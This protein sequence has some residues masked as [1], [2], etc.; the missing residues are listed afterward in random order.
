MFAKHLF[1]C[2]CFVFRIFFSL[3]LSSW[4]CL[5]FRYFWNMMPNYL[6]RNG[7]GWQRNQNTNDVPHTHFDNSNECIWYRRSTNTYM[8]MWLLLCDCFDC[9]V[10]N[11]AVTGVI[12]IVITLLPSLS[13]TYECICINVWFWPHQT[14]I[15]Q[16]WT[17]FWGYT[18]GWKCNQYHSAHWKCC[19]S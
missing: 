16:I 4:F 1:V 6:D 19:L 2:L 3:S 7:T 11:V 14:D 5:S 8:H 15:G 18:D 13:P 9:A 12:V 10:A 17:A